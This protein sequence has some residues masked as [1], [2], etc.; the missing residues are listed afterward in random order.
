MGG[1]KWEEVLNAQ[2]Y[3]NTTE[4]VYI[5]WLNAA[6]SSAD[7]IYALASI[8]YYD[9]GILLKSSDG[10]NTWAKSNSEIDGRGV[11][12]AVDPTNHLRL[13]LG[14]WYRGVYR[15]LDGGSTWRAVNNGLPAGA[16]VRA[17]AIDPSD[18]QR[19]YI[20]T[21]GRVYLSNN[22]GDAWS[23]VADELSSENDVLRIAIDPSNPESVFAAVYGEGV[24]RLLDSTPSTAS[25]VKD[26]AP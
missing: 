15:S 6:A 3:L 12:L 23:Q 5:R 7:R 18:P 4:K 26:T 17:V 13:F 10:G 11:C 14:S 19:I 2:E 1:T 20:G 16:Y 8:Q 21:Q 22:G 9:H 25:L 24:Y